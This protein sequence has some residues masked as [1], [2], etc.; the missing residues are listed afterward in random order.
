MPPIATVVNDLIIE[1]AFLWLLTFYDYKSNT[2]LRAVNNLED[3]VSRGQT[4]TAFPFQLTLF[5]DDGE[6]QPNLS[7]TFPNV[8]QELVT[9][10]RQYE[11]DKPPRIKFELVI[12]NAL[13]TVEKTIDF[14]TVASVQYDAMQMTFNLAS[15]FIFNRKTCTKTYNTNEFPGIFFAIR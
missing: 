15:G 3:I 5:P 1:E 6:K 12:S 2:V 14:L 13:D 8:G 7:L 4:Y 10:V 9:L 11:A